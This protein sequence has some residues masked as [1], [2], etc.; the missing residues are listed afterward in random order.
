MINAQRIPDRV[1]KLAQKEQRHWHGPLATRS[2]ER[3][4]HSVLVTLRARVGLVSTIW[5]RRT[6]WP[7]TGC[8]ARSWVHPS[9]DSTWLRRTCGRVCLRPSSAESQACRRSTDSSSTLAQWLPCRCR[10]RV[11][12]G[13]GREPLSL[14]LAEFRGCRLV[15]HGREL[16]TKDDRQW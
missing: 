13:S 6:V 8:P 1:L 9:L 12:A 4:A 10:C 3:N 7:S 11:D 16:P 5:A 15:S 2:T 14:V